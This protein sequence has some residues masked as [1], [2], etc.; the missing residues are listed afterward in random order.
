M[1]AEVGQNT[2]KI[3]LSEVKAHGQGPGGLGFSADVVVDYAGSGGTEYGQDQPVR[4][5]GTGA[6]V[7]NARLMR[8]LVVGA[9]LLLGRGADCPVLC[10]DRW[11]ACIHMHA[12]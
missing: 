7:L 9:G 1:L 11:T 4:D 12:H 2:D 5:E 8:L 3:S 6:G 10:V